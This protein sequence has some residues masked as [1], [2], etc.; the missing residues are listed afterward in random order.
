MEAKW[1]HLNRSRF[2]QDHR[3]VIE[4]SMWKRQCLQLLQCFQILSRECG[5]NH[6][7]LQ[8]TGASHLRL[9]EEETGEDREEREHELPC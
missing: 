7:E 4:D 1:T 8:A 9:V 2:L 3:R 5:A 6:L